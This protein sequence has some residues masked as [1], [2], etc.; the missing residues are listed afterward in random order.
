MSEL[1]ID[2]V[3]DEVP[4][5]P[6]EVGIR[7]TWR[8]LQRFP[9]ILV[10]TA[11]IAALVLAGF[12]SPL[13]HDP[14]EPNV[15]EILQP[16]SSTYW[17]GTDVNGFDIFS[18]TIDAA[19]RD[20]P[21]ALIGAL[22]SL[23]LGVPLGLMAS[24]KGKAGERIMRALDVFQAFPLIVLSVALVTVTGNELRNV[25]WA[26]AIINVPRFMRL[27]RSEALSLRE[28]RFMEAA[29]A[30]G[31]TRTRL[32]FRHMLPNVVGITLVQ[33]SLAAAHALIVIASL[34][35]L[36]I[37]VTPPDASWGAMIQA[38]ARQMATGEWWVVTFPGLAVL[39]AVA[40]FNMVADSLDAFFDRS[41]A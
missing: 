23:V 24:T 28:S 14:I 33:T 21:L 7:A 6:Q 39:I 25:L 18:R 22:L 32:M 26:I 36:G 13:P 20:I 35:F 41:P 40:S 19:Q 1:P 16:P 12:F 2:L 9:A 30:V 29:V 4:T 37:G 3:P 31:C 27:V 34:S 38:G 10:G 8:R 11:V 5:G 15:L 17:F